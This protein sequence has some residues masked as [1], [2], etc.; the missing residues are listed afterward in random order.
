MENERQ[1]I[2]TACS[3]QRGISIEEFIWALRPQKDAGFGTNKLED[4]LDTLH[5]Q[6]I[7]GEREEMEKKRRNK[8]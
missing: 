6:M 5:V 2:T 8:R 7:E 1:P 4:R 3:M